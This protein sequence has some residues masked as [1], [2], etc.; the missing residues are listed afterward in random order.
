MTLTLRIVKTCIIAATAV[1]LAVVIVLSAPVATKAGGLGI[2]DPAT[3]ADRQLTDEKQF[4]YAEFL[5][6]MGDHATA[7]REYK[8]LLSDFPESPFAERASFKAGEALF[9]AGRYAEAEKAFARFTENHPAS[10]LGENAKLLLDASREL[11]GGAIVASQPDVH[12][13]AHPLSAVQVMNFSGKSFAEIEAEFSNLSRAGIDTVIMRV[14]HNRGDNIYPVVKAERDRIDA[15]GLG[16]ADEVGVYFSTTHSPVVEDILADVVK[17][18]HRHGIKLFAW[19]T[20]KYADYGVEESND[21]AC[22]GFDLRSRRVVR[23]KGLDLLNEKSIRR[24]EAI[25]S[26][27]ASYD[28]DGVLFQ[29]DLVLRHNEGYG[30]HAERAF[31]SEMGREMN[32]DLFYRTTPG[33][34]S[35]DYTARFWEWASWKNQKL[36][37]VAE[38]LMKTVRKKRPDAKFAINMMYEAVTN[39]GY[40]LAWLS[41]DLERAKRVG[42]D[43]YSIMS[44]HRQMGGE[45]GKTQPE[46]ARLIVALVKEAVRVIGD[47]HKVLIKLQTMDWDSRQRLPHSEILALARS[48]RS[49]EDVSLAVVPYHRDFPFNDLTTTLKAARRAPGGLASARP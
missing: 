27:L 8:R 38:R 13:A 4:M 42:F 1:A 26:D 33:A 7:G 37:G 21:L 49:A 34:S 44:Y 39:P 35:V 43:Y 12:G 5:E 14:F 47:P 40:G 31:M 22:K 45:L 6:R 17:I 16:R 20:T 19:M 23:C 41:Q 9:I 25:Y 46:V 10:A 3:P 29:D 30:Q 18:S 48:V 36:L 15:G 24:L 32:P 28:I 11:K 2:N